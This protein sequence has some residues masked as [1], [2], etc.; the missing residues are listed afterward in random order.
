M[1]LFLITKPNCSNCS[2][3]ISYL[4]DNNILFEEKSFNS[5]NTKYIDSLI[6]IHNIKNYPI[7]FNVINKKHYFIENFSNLKR[8]IER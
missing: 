6:K 3:I 4:K 1:Q 5:F 2:F 7:I 8:L